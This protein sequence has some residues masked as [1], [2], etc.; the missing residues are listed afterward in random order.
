MHPEST[1]YHVRS[2][3]AEQ[4]VFACIDKKQKNRQASWII[5][6]VTYT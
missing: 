1:C 3:Q 2:F 6:E 5:G 4:T